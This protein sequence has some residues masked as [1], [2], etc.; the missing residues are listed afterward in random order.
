MHTLQEYEAFKPEYKNQ[1]GEEIKEEIV[2][3]LGAYYLLILFGLHQPTYESFSWHQQLGTMIE[4]KL[5]ELV[6]VIG[7]DRD[8]VIEELN[9]ETV[10]R[11]NKLLSFIIENCEVWP[12]IER[13]KASRWAIEARDIAAE[14]D[15][16]K[17]KRRVA[18]MERKLE[19]AA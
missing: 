8:W 18:M 3:N 1:S 5:E 11:V 16:A 6:E 12:N 15:L 4:E 10:R 9:N 2:A 19:E 17:L 14:T 7:V 13:I